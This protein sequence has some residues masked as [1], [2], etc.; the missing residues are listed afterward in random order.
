M[1]QPHVLADNNYSHLNTQTNLNNLPLQ[2]SSIINQQHVNLQPQ[3]SVLFDDN[4]FTD[5]DC[6]LTEDY[7]TNPN[8]QSENANLNSNQVQIDWTTFGSSIENTNSINTD[9]NDFAFNNFE[10]KIQTNSYLEPLKS[11]NASKLAA[12]LTSNLYANE[13]LESITSLDSNELIPF[14]NQV[15]ESNVDIISD[16]KTKTGASSI[17][18]TKQ[19]KSTTRND[20]NLI[21]NNKKN[22]NQLEVSISST[23]LKIVEEKDELLELLTK[24]T[25]QSQPK[26]YKNPSNKIY[27][28]EFKPTNNKS[29]DNS[30]KLLPWEIKSK[31]YKSKF[32]ITKIN[33]TYQI[34]FL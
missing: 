8:T 11:T 18:I 3:Q 28:E 10:E 12:Q 21:P 14:Q 34:K 31:D 2:Q 19:R 32:L 15:K 22:S 16:S 30:D 29:N 7:N 25:Q 9:S 23:K 24:P 17:F 26:T 6:L 13:F 27:I 20:L 1:N 4:F 33:N 5:I